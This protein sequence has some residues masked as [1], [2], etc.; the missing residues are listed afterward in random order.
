[1]RLC[2]N[3]EVLCTKETFPYLD[4]SLGRILKGFT[5]HNPLLATA[6]PRRASRLLLSRSL[7]LNSHVYENDRAPPE[8]ACFLRCARASG[9]FP[10]PPPRT[11]LTTLLTYISRVGSEVVTQLGFSPTTRSIPIAMYIYHHRQRSVITPTGMYDDTQ[12]IIL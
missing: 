10:L 8:N 6:M 11:F 12:I 7:S 9:Y 2:V 1:M 4:H 3:N 5:S